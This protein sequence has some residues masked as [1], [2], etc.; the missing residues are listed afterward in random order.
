MCL[1]VI[2][3]WMRVLMDDGE[4]REKVGMSYLLFRSRC[5]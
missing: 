1:P 5:L 2:V 4:V 3:L